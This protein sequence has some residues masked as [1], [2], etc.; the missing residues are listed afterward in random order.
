M[1]FVMSVYE[2]TSSFPESEK[3][4]LS[5]QMRRASISIPSNIAEGA[6]RLSRKDFSRYLNISL[7]SSSELE[8]QLIL[9][10]KLGYGDAKLLLSDLE[11]IRKMLIGLIRSLKSD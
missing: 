2:Y 7:G 4:G 10:Y 5:S 8:T 9:A 1:D 3:F 11:A 6:G